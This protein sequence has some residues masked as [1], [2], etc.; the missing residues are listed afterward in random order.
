MFDFFRSDI[1]AAVDFFTNEMPSQR[2]SDEN[3]EEN[4]R[5]YLS[6][7]L[8]KDKRF[9]SQQVDDEEEVELKPKY[10]A[11]SSR[12]FCFIVALRLH[13]GLRKSSISL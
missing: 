2:S 10:A 9:V 5:D 11:L 4:T 6:D 13:M 12:Y 3:K 8:V 7:I 1:Q